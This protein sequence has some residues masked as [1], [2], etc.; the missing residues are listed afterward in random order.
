MAVVELEVVEKWIGKDVSTKSVVCVEDG[1]CGLR[2][3]RVGKR[4][5]HVR[6]ATVLGGGRWDFRLG[7]RRKTRNDN[8]FRIHSMSMD[9]GFLIGDDVVVFG[10]DVFEEWM[11]MISTFL[12]SS[13]VQGRQD[14]ARNGAT[15][16]FILP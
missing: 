2:V 11:F 6:T 4:R 8:C 9:E 3:G 7:G 12:G 13:N 15:K 5:K 16:A 1:G 10:V 14:T